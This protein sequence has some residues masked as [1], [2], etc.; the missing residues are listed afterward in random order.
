MSERLS[1]LLLAVTLAS[2]PAIAADDAPKAAKP[3]DAPVAAPS[4][5][6]DIPA[7][8]GTPVKVE[9]R[10][11]VK[12]SH[13]FFTG[14][15]TFFE[16]GDYYNN[17]GLSFSAQMYLNESLGVSAKFSYILSTLNA[18]ASEVFLRSGLIPDS[19]RVIAVAALGGRYSLGYGKLAMMPV[20]SQVVHFD[21]QAI[22]HLGFTMTDRAANPTVMVGPAF[23]VRINEM[24]YAHADLEVT[25]GFED[26]SAGPVAL[27]FLPQLFVGVR[28]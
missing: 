28:L 14:G 1:A 7:L 8:D 18:A 24:F 25:L 15:V 20:L 19:E 26:R 2:A 5:S 16:R 27:G 22:G 4:I 21:V 13:P 17:P 11:L 10:I 9:K 12:A 6:G 23:L 3:A